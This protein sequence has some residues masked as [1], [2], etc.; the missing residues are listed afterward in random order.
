MEFESYK[1]LGALNS[2]GRTS[3]T[4]KWPEFKFTTSTTLVKGFEP[5]KVLT[6]S[7]RTRFTQLALLHTLM[8]TMF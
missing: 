3:D 1:R 5:R 8:G 6:P 4:I 7:V 2:G